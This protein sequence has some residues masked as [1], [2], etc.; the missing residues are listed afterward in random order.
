VLLAHMGGPIWARK[1]DGAWS[2]VKGEYEPGEDPLA[3]ARREFQEETGC[4]P[5][6]GALLEL[7]EL[8]QA[9]GKRI[10]VWAI[11][12]DFDTG[13]VHSNTFT[14]EWPPR[15]GT[16]QQFPEIDRAEWFDVATARVRLVKG[17]VPFLEMLEHRVCDAG[18]GFD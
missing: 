7:G 15:S 1:D 16:V 5:P 17:Q 8:R 14:M 6:A 12:S 13:H 3:A 2:I 9:S 10:I 11:E 4:A 18:Q